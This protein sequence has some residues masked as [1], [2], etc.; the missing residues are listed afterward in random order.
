MKTKIQSALDIRHSAFT[1]FATGL[2][3]ALTWL[4]QWPRLR[5]RA[6]ER[7]AT[8]P[9]SRPMRTGFQTLLLMLALLGASL[10]TP[11]QAGA[12]E[13]RAHEFITYKA[14]ELLPATAPARAWLPSIGLGAYNEDTGSCAG[15]CGPDEDHVFCYP[16]GDIYCTLPHFWS[17]D[18]GIANPTYYGGE[19][20]PNAWIKA[21]GYNVLHYDVC[22]SWEQGLWP[23]A[24]YYAAINQPWVGY[25]R[26]G[27][28]C[29]LLQDMSVPAHVH[30]DKHPGAE[31]YEDG[32]SAAVGWL[33]QLLDPGQLNNGLIAIPGAELG[34]FFSTGVLVT[35]NPPGSA[36]LFG[37]Y[38]LMYTTAQRADFFASTDDWGNVPDPHGWVS[39]TYLAQP[40]EFWPQF[41]YYQDP[42]HIGNDWTPLWVC[43]NP[44]CRAVVSIGGWA[45]CG[46]CGSQYTAP[47]NPAFVIAQ[48]YTLVYAVRAAATLMA[49]YD[50]KIYG[51]IQNLTANPVK[52][53]SLI[54]AA[55][56][57]ASPGDVIEVAPGTYYES[58]KFFGK[59]V[60]LRGKSGA[61]QTTIHG[62]GSAHVIQCV[63]GEGPD[64]IIEGFTIKGGRA[65]G[66]WPDNTG[67]GILTANSS[68][69][70]RG[71]TITGN[72]AGTGGGLAAYGTNAPT[73][74]NCL[75]HANSATN[76]GGGVCADGC[77][78]ILIHCTITGNLATNVGG[79]V[80]CP[81]VGASGV[82]AR[83][84]NCIV[85]DNSAPENPNFGES[86]LEYSCTWPMP[87]NGTGN[88]TN[89]PLFRDAEIEDFRLVPGS[90]CID[91]GVYL[92]GGVANDLA[93]NPRPLDG[94]GDGVA[95][96]DLGALEFNPRPPALVVNTNSNLVGD[97][98]GLSALAS[99]NDLVNCA[100]GSCVGYGSLRLGPVYFPSPY[101]IFPA[102]DAFSINNGN[103]TTTQ[104]G[105]E[106]GAYLPR[107]LA[108]G[109]LPC[110]VR[111]VLNTNSATGGSPKGY[112]ITG[113]NSFA[114]FS[115][116]SRTLANQ[117]FKVECRAV[118]E[119]GFTEL[120]TF[121][122]TPFATGNDG[123][124]STLV[125]LGATGMV[126]AAHV[127]DV[128]LTYMDHGIVPGGV[129]PTVDGTVL[130]EVDIIGFPSLVLSKPSPRQVTQRDG[131]GRGNI[132]IEGSLGHT[133]TR[134]E[135]RAVVMPGTAN[136]GQGT[137][138][139]NIVSTPGNGAFAGT[140]VGVREGGWYLI[141]VR[142]YDGDLLLDEAAVKRVGVG[143]IIITAGQSNAG[144]FGSPPQVPSDDRVSAYNLL[145]GTWQFA[146]DPQPNISG[147]MGTGG[148]PWPR[149]GSMLATN[150]PV[151]P[152][153][154][155]FVGLAYGGSAA[156]Q[157]LPVPWPPYNL[158][159]YQNL[160]NALQRFGSNGVCCV[161][162]H[163]GE[164]DAVF[165]ASSAAYS[166]ILSHIIAQSR[167]DAGWSVPWGIAEATYNPGLRMDQEEA[168][169]A[170]Q[171]AVVY[172][173]ANV[174]RGPR[175]DDFF[176]EGK[177]LPLPDGIH[178]NQMGLD[179]H[180]AQ[181]FQ[182]LEGSD[183]PRP[184]N[185]D[186]EWGGAMNLSDG[187]NYPCTSTAIYRVPGWNLLDASGTTSAGGVSGIY[188]PN[189]P[190]YSLSGDGINGGVLTNMSGRHVA[191]LYSVS[192][193]D[194]FLQTLRAKLQP[195]TIYTLS[196]AIGVRTDL[197]A[198]I[199]GGYRVELLTNG[200]LCSATFGDRATL[201]PLAGGSAFDRF[202]VVS[203]TYTSP[204]SVAPNQQLAIRI[205]KPNGAATPTY[206]DFDNVQV[207][208]KLTPYG[209]WQF[210]NWLNPNS[211]D[212]IPN[213]DPDQDGYSN[214]EEFIA[215]TCP[216]NSGSVPRILQIVLAGSEMRVQ[217]QT[218]LG[219]TYQLEC[220]HGLSPMEWIAVGTAVTGT[221]G[222]TNLI[223]P[224][225]GLASQRFYRV[226]ISR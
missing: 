221:G 132:R 166:Q 6:P 26:L 100:G 31:N 134:V 160:T 11:D 181:W 220:S 127:E 153:P 4:G 165:G 50:N 30:E 123:R 136:T 108:G 126:L 95:G 12:Y 73:A 96:F 112:Q 99:T 9:P 24:V 84:T 172:G 94:N 55:I 8:P 20:W 19:Y 129:Q 63:D 150:N 42:D 16:L 128:V 58:L 140:L 113:I 57:E 70:I 49:L 5:P 157:W 213:A 174:F 10:V 187:D 104:S 61:G 116:N 13:A 163:Q 72:T 36:D 216:V 86:H 145:T 120:G 131:S 141:E 151:N 167:L 21:S 35:G 101:A 47:S 202:T 28:I 53:Y 170:G 59:P 118:G 182:A 224:D 138:W 133:F 147:N 67:G 212:S 171:R 2:G 27:H 219:S 77:S 164:A 40:P 71:C 105:E 54:Q 214:W 45:P 25:E 107:T 204:P 183:D 37:L 80:A 33:L 60:H 178:F 44:D 74:V 179:D 64:T 93:G 207:T 98:S 223:D 196:V 43:L 148:S 39:P 78:P 32:V 46:I 1:P 110:M 225:V 176:W 190:F 69:T 89:A 149:L 152:V 124:S 109:R 168:V 137:D 88:L 222:R 79:G 130:K 114:G 191:F 194:S 122:Y 102:G 185:A 143:D 211:P 195:S 38:Y 192:S 3:A 62:N 206:L 200:Q 15:P 92:V 81:N 7:S 34:K 205:T 68:P 75:F 169:A 180:A 175:T 82:G 52:T 18:G 48:K 162:W 106:D 146:A 217:V 66:A 76:R 209:E 125:S 193:G 201:D 22:G 111:F 161:L 199:F 29:H 208:S 83:L 198:S 177:L 158:P 210:A 23:Q 97:T 155:G 119:V 135:A 184:K 218:C 144:C 117:K 197:P 65:L 17:P 186:F 154:V 85:Y 91:A 226:R 173:N 14:A 215:G 159:L 90:P 139:T 188:N 203:C 121:A 56:W 41:W 189:W 115:I 87:T 142:V 156:C 103:A 51:R